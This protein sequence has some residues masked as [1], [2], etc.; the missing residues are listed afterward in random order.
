MAHWLRLK[1]AQIDRILVIF[2]SICDISENP[3][4]GRDH[5]RRIFRH[6]G[7]WAGMG[8]YGLG[9]T[10]TNVEIIRARP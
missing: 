6:L 7:I 5:N 8:N 9:L 10:A 4:V 1:S 3:V 2:D